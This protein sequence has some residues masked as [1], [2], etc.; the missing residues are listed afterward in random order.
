MLQ[1]FTCKHGA[2]NEPECV[3]TSENGLLRFAVM[4]Y[5]TVEREQTGCVRERTRGQG[6]RGQKIA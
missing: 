3:H 5:A 6:V 2:I 1:Y 4:Y